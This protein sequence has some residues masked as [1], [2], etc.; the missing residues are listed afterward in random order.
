[1][2]DIKFIVLR[3]GLDGE[4]WKDFLPIMSIG[5]L[6]EVLLENKERKLDIYKCKKVHTIN[7]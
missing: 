2:G 1:L 7:G 4:S 3:Y 5:E 6:V